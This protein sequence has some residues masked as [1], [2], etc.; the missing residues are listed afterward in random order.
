VTA[1]DR[2][3]RNHHRDHPPPRRPRWPDLRIARPQGWNDDHRR[4]GDLRLRPINQ[5]RAQLK[6]VSKY[7]TS[8]TRRNRLLGGLSPRTPRIRQSMSSE[9]NGSL[10][11]AA[12]YHVAF[13]V[14]KEAATVARRHSGTASRSRSS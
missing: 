8:A 7:T 14:A 5:A 4:H 1:C 11:A 6:A 9:G 13:D 12:A 2:L 10:P 3:P